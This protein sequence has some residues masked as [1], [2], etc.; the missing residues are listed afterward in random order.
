MSISSPARTRQPHRVP[1]S[2]LCVH[3]DSWFGSTPAHPESAVRLELASGASASPVGGAWWPWSRNL[4]AQAPQLLTAVGSA[5]GSRVVHVVYDRGSWGPVPH[6]LPVGDRYV[7]C[8]WFDLAD[9]HQVSLRLYD[10]RRLVLLVVPPD[11]G[12]RTALRA[13]HQA[14]DP[15]N[16]LSPG[17]ILPR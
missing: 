15:H 13:M 5:C 8:G 12:R 1:A 6:R 11:T 9:P 10:G 2:P 7:K 3:P 14:A 17:Q 4:A 16:R